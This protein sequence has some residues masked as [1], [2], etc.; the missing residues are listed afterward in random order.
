MR[1]V[2]QT[3]DDSSRHVRGRGSA[4]LLLSPCRSCHYFMFRKCC[5]LRLV[6]LKWIRCRSLPSHERASAARCSV[7][8]Q[9]CL[10]QSLNAQQ[11][12]LRLLSPRSNAA[13]CTLIHCRMFASFPVS[14]AG[15]QNGEVVLWDFDTR[16]VLRAFSGHK[17]GHRCSTPTFLA[18]ARSCTN[19]KREA[20]RRLHRPESRLGA[21]VIVTATRL[22]SDA[23]SCRTAVTAVA[24]TRN[25][26]QLLSASQSGE[27]LLFDVLSVRRRRRGR[28]RTERVVAERTTLHCLLP[29]RRRSTG[30]GVF[31][32]LTDSHGLVVCMY[33][34]IS[35]A[36]WLW[37]PRRCVRPAPRRLLPSLHFAPLHHQAPLRPFRLYHNHPHYS[38]SA[39]LCTH[40]GKA[41]R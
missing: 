26:R 10:L 31:L 32:L 34:A 3:R 9:A 7:R 20:L 27:M 30:A 36:K 14:A 35:C 19:I 29:W 16:G 22:W 39:A 37:A 6:M 41:S 28:R 5:M 15:C 4:I 25:G 23:L 38:S 13:V 18:P 2:Q 33:R 12:T 8:S 11:D 24:W 1:G 17:C 21:S 40:I